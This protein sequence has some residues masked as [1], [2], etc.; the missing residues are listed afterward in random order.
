MISRQN[1]LRNKINEISEITVST[2]RITYTSRS[3][4]EICE[5]FHHTSMWIW[6]WIL[7]WIL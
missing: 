7:L 1:L 3:A 4:E 6:L 2:A 5:Y